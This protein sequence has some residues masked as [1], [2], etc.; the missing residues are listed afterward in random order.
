MSHAIYYILYDTIFDRHS[1][2]ESELVPDLF[3]VGLQVPI[4]KSIEIFIIL[5]SISP[6]NAGVA[7]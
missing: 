6:N 2:L 3:S 5:L 7:G 1:I 4:A